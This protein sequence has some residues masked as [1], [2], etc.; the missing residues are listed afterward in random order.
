VVI[1]LATGSHAPNNTILLPRRA[2][3]LPLIT[4]IRTP[5]HDFGE[6]ANLRRDDVRLYGRGFAHVTFIWRNGRST[7]Q[8]SDPVTPNQLAVTITFDA[9]KSKLDAE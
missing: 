2:E 4:R 8:M 5:K 7:I 6:P 9:N 1:T 3:T